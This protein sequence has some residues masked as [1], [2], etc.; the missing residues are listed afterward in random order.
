MYTFSTD[1]CNHAVYGL[2][3]MNVSAPLNSQLKQLVIHFNYIM[4]L[5]I[6]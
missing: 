5:I 6:Y 1:T 2:L 4:T 3:K